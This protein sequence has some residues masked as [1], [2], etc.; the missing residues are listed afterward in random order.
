[1]SEEAPSSLAALRLRMENAKIATN[2]WGMSNIVGKTAEELVE[3]DLQ[4]RKAANEYI[5]A[6]VAYRKA[7]EAEIRRREDN[8]DR[9]G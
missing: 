9:G 4:S 8:D 1:M 3:L 2:V 5:E 6:S 7:L